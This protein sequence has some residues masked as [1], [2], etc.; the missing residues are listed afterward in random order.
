MDFSSVLHAV[1][2]PL[3]KMLCIFTSAVPQAWDLAVGLQEKP[4]KGSL[5]V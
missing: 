4:W 1:L 5:V 3:G 2:L